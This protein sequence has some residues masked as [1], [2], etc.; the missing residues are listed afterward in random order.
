VID[1]VAPAFRRASAECKD[2]T[3]TGGALQTTLIVVARVIRRGVFLTGGK[4]ALAS[5]E[6]SYKFATHFARARAMANA[7]RRTR[8]AATVRSNFG[9]SSS[10]V[11]AN[12]LASLPAHNVPPFASQR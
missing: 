4:Q 9:N 7:F 2:A 1:F 5:E 8:V 6:A 10:R 3:L 11:Q 12:S